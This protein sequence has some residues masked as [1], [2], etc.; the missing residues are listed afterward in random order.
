MGLF[1]KTSAALTELED[2]LLNHPVLIAVR[3]GLTYMIP[4]LMAGSMALVFLSLPIPLYQTF[5]ADTFGYQWKSFFL[6]IRDGTFN[7]LAILMTLTISYS[8]ASELCEMRKSALSP[9]IT[10]SVSLCSFMALSGF[11]SAAFSAEHVGV[12]SAFTAIAVAVSSSMLFV[13][14]T[15]IPA[16]RTNILMESGN[17]TFQYAVTSIYPAMIT[18]AIFSGLNQGMMSFWGISDIH[19]FISDSIC[20]LFSHL[21][22]PFWG[23]LLFMGLV[24]SFWF[25]GMHGSNILEPVA[26]EFFVPALAANQLSLSVGSA[27]TEVF[28]KTFFDTFVLMGGC[29]T[30]LCLV[31][32]ILLMGK[33]KNHHRLAR[34][35]L[36]PVLFNI[37]ELVIFG[38]PLVLNPIFMIPFLA[39]PL[40][41]TLI[42][43]GAI[44]SGLVPYTIHSV[45]WTTPVF[46][47]GFM[48]TESING[49]ILQGFNLL[50]GALCYAP[51][52]KLS[53]SVAEN[54]A[55]RTL[56]KV[57]SCFK[58]NEERGIASSLLNRTD[59]IGHVAR[60]LAADLEQDLK[61]NQIKIFYQP[62]LKYPDTV[63]CAEAL[64][65]WH[66]KSYGAI[67]PPLVIALAE[68]S[69][70]MDRLGFWI[71]NTACY[72]LRQLLDAGHSDMTM[73]VNISA[74]Q[75]ENP[76]FAQNTERILTNHGLKPES[77]I[78][79]ITEQIALAN[80]PQIINQI[81]ALNALGIKLAMDDFGMGHSSLMYLKEHDFDTL[82]LDGSLV[83]E[84]L[85]NTNCRNIISSIVHLGQSL[86]YSVVAEYVESTE[87]RELLHELGCNQYQGYLYSPAIPVDKLIMY[88]ERQNTDSAISA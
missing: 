53:E 48:A 58:E 52:I 36:V 14:L 29:G 33:N 1:E 41:L 24:H 10:A 39:T 28:T 71:L 80:S 17:S 77:L 35:S 61:E 40:L 15:S 42:S 69:H 26:R 66:H 78:I 7:I 18:V 43:Y 13:K 83:R 49:S 3:R 34:L 65:R 81:L 86:N 88:I 87:Q 54:Q 25:F 38:L 84:I 44:S 37:N 22:S 50:L 6:F 74:A 85:T 30:S 2:T 32:A 73:S 56:D 64:L 82:K 67:Y 4:L 46:L 23:A 62:L 51:F 8:Y 16:L 9:I 72:D 19:R 68:E 47:S 75:L 45:E 5:M 27:P 59:D 63:Y 70:L 60:F 31:G 21:S 12:S 76:D 20:G 55:K 79:E 11:G 57:C